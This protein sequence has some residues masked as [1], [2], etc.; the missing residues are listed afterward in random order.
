M[1]AI[2]VELV[3]TEKRF[4]QLKWRGIVSGTL[5]I[6]FPF[7]YQAVPWVGSIFHLLVT[8]LLLLSMICYLCFWHT[9]QI[10]WA[11]FSFFFALLAPL[12]HEIG[13][14]A[15]PLIIVSPYFNKKKSDYKDFLIRTVWI[16]PIF[17]WFFLRS[18]AE[19]SGAGISFVNFES[20]FQ[21]GAYLL[22]GVAYP[23]TG[24]GGWLMRQF[25][26]NDMVTAVTLSTITIILILIIQI[27]Y[28]FKKQF[29]VPW[30][31]IFFAG[32][33]FILFLKFGYVVSAPRLLM[34]AS[35]GIA[36]LWADVLWCIHHII[37]SRTK[38]QII[39]KGLPVG[40]FILLIV[41]NIGFL[42]QHMFLHN[43]LGSVTQEATQL[44]KE[45]DK[46]LI[47]VN[48]PAWI[49]FKD[50]TYPLGHEGV[51]FMTEYIPD[52]QLISAQLER[53]FDFSLLKY[54]DLQ[55]ESPYYFDILG[56]GTDWP[57]L[58]ATGGQLYLTNL[59][60]KS[61]SLK[62]IGGFSILP[63]LES[64]TATF[65]TAHGHD[66]IVL[67]SSRIETTPQGLKIWL[68]WKNV[69]PITDDLTVF[70]H[71]VDATGQLI[72]Q[73]D[74]YPLSGMYP[75]NIWPENTLLQDVRYIDEFSGDDFQTFVGIYDRVTG[76]RLV[77]RNEHNEI[78][79]NNAAILPHNIRR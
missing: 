29:L 19:G 40:L 20:M 64:P 36:W 77:A 79:S 46:P 55:Q 69:T 44:V 33:P 76:Q 73:N 75:I 1:T 22:Q 9:K 45:A 3:W 67:Q 61:I 70:V 72:A 53:E 2:L 63:Q 38:S 8:T 52:K 18:N 39:Q 42:K 49:A 62:L 41:Q 47:F 27:K 78:L 59:E 13:V 54:N 48:L 23:I 37:R 5:F 14:L 6:L 4:P 66:V 30:M 60:E 58:Y 7:S 32:L 74:G 24:F 51:V 35:V 21:N 11:I 15:A 65:A 10:F 56:E 16:I 71:I 25:E 68:E 17:I 12:A 34:F 26:L 57:A 50:V 28:G 43:M 31:I